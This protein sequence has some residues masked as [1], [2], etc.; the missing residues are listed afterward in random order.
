MDI[1]SHV[2]ENKKL[3]NKEF[4]NKVNRLVKQAHENWKI[5]SSLRPNKKIITNQLIDIDKAESKGYVDI[6]YDIES[7][8]QYLNAVFGEHDLQREPLDEDDN[9]WDLASKISYLF[10]NIKCLSKNKKE[11]YLY[12]EIIKGK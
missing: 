8:L 12:K 1:R 2:L 7:S 6:K 5:V 3:F 9:T 4:I 11:L 10:G